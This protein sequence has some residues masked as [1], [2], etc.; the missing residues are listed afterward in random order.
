MEKILRV[1]NLILKTSMEESGVPL[2]AALPHLKLLEY[3]QGWWWERSVLAS[4][5]CATNRT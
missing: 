1:G 2:M 5:L 4:D 3:A